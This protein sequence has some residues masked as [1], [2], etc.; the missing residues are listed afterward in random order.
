MC[1]SNSDKKQYKLV[2]VSDSHG[3]TARLE[4]LLPVINSAD[5]LVFCGD[6]ATDV[7]WLSGRITAPI[8]CVKGNND[9]WLKDRITD[10]ATFAIGASRAL[11]VHG[12]RHNVRQSLSLLLEI[13]MLKDYKLVF[14]GHTHKYA[15]AVYDGIHFINPGALCEGSYAIVTGDGNN[16]VVEN[17]FIV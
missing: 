6:G 13:A 16:F 1:D 9:F 11:V 5:R 10:I 7:L 3:D 15:D 2:V 14:F 8:V 4:R 12:H 17:R